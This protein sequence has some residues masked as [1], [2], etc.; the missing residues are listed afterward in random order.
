LRFT[1]D[2]TLASMTTDGFWGRLNVSD[3]GIVP[4]PPMR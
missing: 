3:G 4:P 1:V 2:P